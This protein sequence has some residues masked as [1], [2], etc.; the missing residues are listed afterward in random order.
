MN[1][2]TESGYVF[3]Y[4][5]DNMKIKNICLDI[6]DLVQFNS[7]LEIIFLNK[8]CQGNFGIWTHAKSIHNLIKQHS[9]SKGR[10]KLILGLLPQAKDRKLCSEFPTVYVILL[11]THHKPPLLRLYFKKSS[12][13]ELFF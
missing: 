4:S 1:K 3:K 6:W 12:T 13:S 8:L 9:D 10:R 2:A 11:A 5:F 7:W